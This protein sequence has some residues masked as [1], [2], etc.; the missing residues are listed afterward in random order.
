[1]PDKKIALYG[2]WK[3]PTTLDLI[4]AETVSLREVA[5][6]GPDI[7][8][9]EQRPTE[10]GRY[11]VVRRTPDGRAAD[12]TPAGYNARTT[13]HE[14]GGGSYLA[15]GGMVYFSNFEDQRRYRQR[16]GSDPE[17]LSPAA[18]IRYADGAMDTKRGRI[19]CVREDHGNASHEAVNTIVSLDSERGGEGEILVPPWPSGT[20]SR[21]VRATS[22]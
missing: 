2:A 12:V 14:Y 6:D 10:G 5:V 1:L 13:V 7:Y 8:W 22:A 9:L 11:V 19:I 16:L 21:Q 3:S 18:D 15:V 17:P 4:V 20:S